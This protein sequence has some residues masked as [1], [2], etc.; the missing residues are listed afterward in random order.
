[1]FSD[2]TSQAG[3]DGRSKLLVTVVVPLYMLLSYSTT[4]DHSKNIS[5]ELYQLV[6]AVG[7][8]DKAAKADLLLVMTSSSVPPTAETI[9][10]R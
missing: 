3:V 6:R 7:I 1:M 9:F 5:T 4:I 8:L 10:P 2:D